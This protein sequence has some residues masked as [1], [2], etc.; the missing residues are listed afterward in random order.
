VF[1]CAGIYK[2]KLRLIREHKVSLVY[3]ARKGG[4]QVF[5]ASAILYYLSARSA[6]VSYG[7]FEQ[8]CA[9]R[10]L[11]LPRIQHPV[12]PREIGERHVM[13]KLIFQIKFEAMCAMETEAERVR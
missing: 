3:S 12:T 4:A 6:R 8:S 5:A 2:K 1:G 13:G 11:S 7:I 9:T 10:R